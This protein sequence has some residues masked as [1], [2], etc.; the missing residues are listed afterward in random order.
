MSRVTIIC[1]SPGSGKS[2]YV[3][4]HM[5]AGDLI[6][7]LDWIY[8]A[9][10]GRT[11]REKDEA[12]MPFMWEIRDALYNRLTKPNNIKQAWIVGCLPKA[13]DRES[14]AKRFNAD[15]ILINKTKREC[16]QQI[17]SDEGRLSD[18]SIYLKWMSDWFSDYTPR[19]QDRL[20]TTSMK[21]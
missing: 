7:D 6:I 12:L 21:G 10:S 11:G 13:G 8:K 3:R 17:L 20:V 9:I 14:L 19:E 15:V 16:M 1:G 4:E 5:Q 2:T 18:T